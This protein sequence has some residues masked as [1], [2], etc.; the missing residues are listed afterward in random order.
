[1]QYADLPSATITP[2]SITVTE[3][4][5]ARFTCNAQGSGVLEVAW[6]LSGDRPLPVGVQENGNS[7]YIASATSS[8]P[9]TY[10]CSVI[11]LAGTGLAEA[12]LTVY[13]E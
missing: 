5:E 12:T 11:N 3:G 13:C 2:T 1:M 6:A 7:I 9:G 8:H 4:E 10:V